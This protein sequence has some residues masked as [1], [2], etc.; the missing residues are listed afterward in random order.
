L[1]EATDWHRHP[2]AFAPQRATPYFGLDLSRREAAVCTAW[3]LRSI[4]VCR[5]GAKARHRHHG[6]GQKRQRRQGITG[7]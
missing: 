7:D 1:L 4:N 3:R 6:C 5:S 2:E